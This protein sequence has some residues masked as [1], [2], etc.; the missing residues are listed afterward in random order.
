MFRFM[1]KN[2]TTLTKSDGV[3]LPT[4]KSRGYHWQF[5]CKKG[6][7]G[8]LDDRSKKGVI[9]CETAQHL[10]NF[11]IFAAIWNF[12]SKFDDFSKNFDKKQ[13]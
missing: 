12:I 5:S 13:K 9:G 10:G 11:N 3:H 1:F 8:M 7:I 4:I 6:V 2:L